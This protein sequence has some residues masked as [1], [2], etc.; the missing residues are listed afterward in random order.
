LN[1]VG[2]KLILQDNAFESY[3]TDIVDICFGIGAYCNL[4]SVSKFDRVSKIN[5]AIE[6]GH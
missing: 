3:N 5:R 1:K 4:G 6:I 2:T